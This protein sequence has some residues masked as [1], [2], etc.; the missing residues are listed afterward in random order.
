M[1]ATGLTRRSDVA[2]RVFFDASVVIAG[3]MSRGGASRALLIL[4]EAGLFRMVVSRQVLDEVE[5]NLRNKLPQA[6]PLMVELLGHIA[7]EVVDDPPSEAFG[8]WLRHIEA[9][10]APILEAAVSAQ[11]DYLVTL[12]SRDFTPEV[13]QVSGLIILS[14]GA[15][16]EQIREI[17][18]AGPG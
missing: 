18:T 14:P 16:M 8:R 1:S 4:A 7:P 3:S 13:A 5:R 17:V 6:L 9:K 15:L 2:R 11:V 12:N 10:D